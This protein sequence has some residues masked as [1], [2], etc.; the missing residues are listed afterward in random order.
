MSHIRKEAREGTSRYLSDRLAG[1]SGRVKNLDAGRTLRRNCPDAGE[2]LI[3]EAFAASSA[4]RTAFDEAAS[5]QLTQL[6]KHLDT[7]Q[8]TSSHSHNNTRPTQQTPCDC[9]LLISF[10]KDHERNRPY[11][12][13]AR[14]VA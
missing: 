13:E 12:P 1:T 11:H 9:H 7:A 4:T 14:Q 8:C 6:P 5:S 2:T 10:P 3:R